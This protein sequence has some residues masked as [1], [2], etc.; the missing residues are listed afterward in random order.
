MK[1]KM[2]NEDK[3]D[4]KSVLNEQL[5]L[6]Q[7]LLPLLAQCKNPKDFQ[8]TYDDILDCNKVMMEI[9]CGPTGGVVKLI[10][11]NL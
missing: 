2:N 3:N 6:I 7:K 5:D 9:V 10:E 8:S 1:N 11:R 4:L